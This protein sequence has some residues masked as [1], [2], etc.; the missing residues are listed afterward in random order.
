MK[1]RTSAT[2]APT[3]LMICTGNICRSPMAE[4]LLRTRLTRECLTD[5]IQVHSSGT[6]GI[7]GSPASAYAITALHRMGIDIRG[8]RARTVTQQTVDEANLLLAMT[9]GHVSFIEQHFRRTESK[10]YL[11]SEMIGQDF[12]VDDPYGGTETEYAQC[13]HQLSNIVEQGLQTILGL[14]PPFTAGNTSYPRVPR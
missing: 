10:L 11:L 6:H 2:R 3:V 8:H 12:D 14:L 4:W 13:A 1:I 9:H 7:D 5:Q